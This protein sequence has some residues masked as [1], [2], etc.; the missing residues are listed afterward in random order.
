MQWQEI[1]TG[2]YP[3]DLADEGVDAV[4][5]NLKQ[6]AGCTAA[7]L[8]A[9][10][11][12]EKRPYRDHYYPHNPVRKRYIAE[13]SRAYWHPDPSFYR[14]LRLAPRTSDRGFLAGTDWL[15]AF[16][17]A[18]RA[19]G[20]SPGVEIS[21]TPLDR[22]RAMAD[23]RDC[24]QTNV[25][26]QIIHG[27]ERLCWNSEDARAYV[28][29]IARE[30]VTR[31]DVDMLQACCYPYTQGAP[32]PHSLLGVA[33]GSCFCANCARA[34]TAAGLDWDAI[35]R[36]VRYWADVMTNADIVRREDKLLLDRGGSSEV[37]LLVEEP[38]L[39]DWLRFR[40]DSF[41]A[42]MEELS[43][44]VH[45]ARPGIDFR[46]NTCH[47]RPELVGVDLPRIARCVDS[48]RIMDYT[49]QWG[50][51]TRM[52]GKSRW[53][54][55]VR[56]QAGEDLPIIGAIG[57][58][59]DA[60]PELIA[61][62]IR[63]NARHGADGL[64]FGFYDGASFAMLRALRDGVAATGITVGSR[65]DRGISRGERQTTNGSLSPTGP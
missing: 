65:P 52:D 45:A 23:H 48:I 24:L 49:E 4:C 46:H 54:A 61:E 13:D 37:T 28:T 58:R 19:H 12:L 29:A 6:E 62:G 9:L 32:D 59:A 5:R 20:L 30:L 33:L 25:Y 53:L 8:I 16:T 50:D 40:C 55:D 39:Y 44:A 36:R 15:A 14:G 42:Y 26:G 57:C 3:W 60:T 63:I 31:Y 56:R 22:E 34:A 7:Y 2:V 47:R 10:M 1:T 64:S 51:P 41:S 38:L 18:M 35:T 43:D 21:H 27:G 17:A 11:H